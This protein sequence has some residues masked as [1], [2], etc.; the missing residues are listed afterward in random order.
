MLPA[1]RHS[2]A[3]GRGLI[4]GGRTG[5]RTAA[6]G[7]QMPATGPVASGNCDGLIPGLFLT[8]Q[9]RPRLLAARPPRAPP[10]QGAGLCPPFR[11]PHPGR[12][13]GALATHGPEPPAGR[14]RPSRALRQAGSSRR[15]TA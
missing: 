6:R 7:R 4:A 15:M 10:A 9:P 2:G 11:R 13:A 14:V 1:S 12:A 3:L 5:W 8:I